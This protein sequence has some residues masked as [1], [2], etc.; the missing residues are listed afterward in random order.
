M[1]F[2][3]DFRILLKIEYFAL[4]KIK[5]EHHSTIIMDLAIDILE[6]CRRGRKRSILFVCEHFAHKPDEERAPLNSIRHKKNRANS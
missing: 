2:G 3:L 5:K 4:S 1:S 6:D